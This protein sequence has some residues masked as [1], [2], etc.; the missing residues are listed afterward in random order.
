MRNDKGRAVALLPLL[1]VLSEEAGPAAGHK[2]LE[3]LVLGAALLPCVPEDA[4][5][6]LH[7]RGHG[8]EHL[9]QRPLHV[10][11]RVMRL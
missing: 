6:A 1:Q 5:L 8:R 9:C 7:G 10:I 4:A 2:P 3:Q 11:T